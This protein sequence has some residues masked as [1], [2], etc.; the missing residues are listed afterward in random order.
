MSNNQPG[1]ASTGKITGH[2]PGGKVKGSVDGRQ[3][4]PPPPPKK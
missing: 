3:I 1:G 4:A 2:A